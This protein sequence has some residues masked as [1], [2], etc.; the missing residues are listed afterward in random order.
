LNKGIIYATSAYA[1]WGLVPIFWKQLDGVPAGETLGHRI[2]WSFL[3]LVL[4]SA[5]RRNWRWLPFSTG[6]RS[7]LM[8]SLVTA[9]LLGI[10][11]FTYIWAINAGFIVE[12]SLGYFINPLINVLLAVAFLK[13]SVRAGQWLAIL[14]A[15]AGVG[16]LT[17]SYGRLPWVALTLAFTFGFY[18][19]LR[20]QAS[21]SALDGLT[22]EMGIVAFPALGFLIFLESSAAGTFG[23]TGLTTMS[24]MVFSGIVTAVPLLLFGAGAKRVSLVTLGVLQYLAPT[25]QLVLGVF[26][27]HE[28]FPPERLVGFGLIWFA[29]LLY[30][31]EGMMIARR[32]ARLRYGA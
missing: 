2:V 14:V 30:S 22:L 17:L 5:L 28:P 29:L 6:R 7:M 4:V 24:L 16:W 31:L 25:M 1:I 9:A 21:S 18:G 32:L 10:N 13:E 20:K 23:R 12:S 27:Y 26:I 11:W 15:A 3:L 8:P 19:L